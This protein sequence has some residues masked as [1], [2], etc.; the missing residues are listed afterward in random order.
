MQVAV[1]LDITLSSL[2]VCGKRTVVRIVTVPD[3]PTVKQFASGGCRRREGL[4]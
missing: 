1:S 2:G 4:P 3:R